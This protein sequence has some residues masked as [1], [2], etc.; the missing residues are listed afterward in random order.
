MMLDTLPRTQRLA[1]DLLATLADST[2][3]QNAIERMRSLRA[4]PGRKPGVCA[5]H[6]TIAAARPALLAALQHALG[7]TLLVILPTPDAAERSYADLLYYLGEH[8]ERV[9]LL[10]SRDEALGAIESPSERSA[11]ITLLADLADEKARLILAPIAAVRQRFMARKDFEDN[12]LVLRSGDEPG[13]EQLIERLF[14]LGYTRC[15][16]VSAVGEYAVRGGIVDLFA[17]TSETPVRIEFFGDRIESMRSFAIESQRS[18]EPV[19]AVAVAPWS[20]PCEGGAT[21]LDYLPPRAAIVLDEPPTIA[22][23]AQALDEERARERHTLLAGDRQD[24]ALLGSIPA[25]I[26]LKEIGA[27]LKAWATL[28]FPGGI[29]TGPHVDWVAPALESY[30]FECLPIEHFNRQIELFAGAMR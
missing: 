28:V 6:E 4:L 16:V 25:T 11:R 26:S 20:D 14:R 2:A 8:S 19:N 15:D 3:W 10:R 21:L 27:S 5:L 1:E 22:A 24:E 17:A 30:V 29:E 18:N 9:A 23:V 13:W 7:G 12:R